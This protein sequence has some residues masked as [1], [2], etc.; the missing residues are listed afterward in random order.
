M[1]INIAL[2]LLA[3]S[4]YLHTTEKGTKPKPF[5]S[6]MTL[7][8]AGARIAEAANRGPLEGDTNKG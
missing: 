8:T 7:E 1:Q 4:G 6:F 2:S 3:Q 5:F